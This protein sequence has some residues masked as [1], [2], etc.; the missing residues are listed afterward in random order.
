MQMN[1][2]N[3]HLNEAAF[4]EALLSEVSQL[5][6]LQGHDR[7][8]VM[9]PH[10]HG[11]ATAI[12]QRVESCSELDN[13]NDFQYAHYA[14]VDD[15]NT[16]AAVEKIRNLQE[17]RRR[18][19]LNDTVEQGMQYL[20]AFMT[21]QPGFVLHLD[22]SAGTYETIRVLDV[23]KLN[24]SAALVVGTGGDLDYNWRQLVCGLY[25]M[26]TACS[27]YLASIRQG[28]FE[29]ADLDGVGAHH[30]NME[31]E[32]R[33]HGELVGC[34]PIK[35]KNI[36]AYN[37]GY[38]A[39]VGWNLM[40]HLMNDNVRSSIQ[41]GCQIMDGAAGG[42]RKLSDFYLQPSL[43]EAQRAVL[44]RARILLT[45]RYHNEQTFQL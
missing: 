15:A 36:M 31:F 1:G 38:F 43:E 40:K 2:N 8:M 42:N 44:D 20:Q 24:P 3:N 29:I 12:K 32:Y 18:Y 25:Y 34:Y 39:N 10:E 45:I 7:S 16:D 13:L 4:Q 5:A 21:Q 17:F 23:S 22:C 19:H 11:N 35:F 30:L 26:H 41:L 27:P 28:V 9:T 37:T 33:R 6:T 14:L